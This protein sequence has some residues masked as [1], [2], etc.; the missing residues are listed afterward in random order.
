MITDEGVHIEDI[1][2][3]CVID[4]ILSRI[5]IAI[6]D[7]VIIVGIVVILG[8]GRTI[9]DVTMIKSVIV[10]ETGDDKAMNGSYLR[11]TRVHAAMITGI[12]YGL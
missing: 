4:G 11:Q 9:D 7:L 5:I 12:S 2:E 6:T 3:T 8:D 10:T 1:T